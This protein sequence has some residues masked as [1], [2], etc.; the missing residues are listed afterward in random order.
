[1]YLNV[2]LGYVTL[3][4]LV[5][6]DPR[7][8]VH[9]GVNGTSQLHDVD[10]VDMWPAITGVNKTNP[11]PWLPT[12]ED[13]ILWQRPDGSILKLITAAKQTNF[14]TADGLHQTWATDPCVWTSPNCIVNCSHSC[15][16]CDPLH[17]C[18]YDVAADP[19]ELHNLAAGPN[20]TTTEDIVALVA[21]MTAKLASYVPYVD[22]E[23]TA[24]EMADYD[25]VDPGD[26]GA[27]LWGNYQGPCCTRKEEQ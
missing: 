25:C 20:T 22:G 2:P 7:D 1:M 24:E 5:G 15:A 8:P 18:L 9:I 23:L 19:S 10:G 26:R 21:E 14:F 12:T 13:S 6:V 4:V 17:P 3:S 27:E 11:R 16:V